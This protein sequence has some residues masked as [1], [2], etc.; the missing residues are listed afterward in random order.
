MYKR[1]NQ[2]G[3]ADLIVLL[4]MSFHWYRGI[5]LQGVSSFESSGLV[6]HLDGFGDS[7]QIADLNADGYPDVVF[8]TT[9]DSSIVWF[10]N[11]RGS[12]FKPAAMVAAAGT[13]PQ[14]FGTQLADIDNDGDLDL[15]VSTRVG[16]GANVVIWFTNDGNGVFERQINIPIPDGANAGRCLSADVDG[17]GYPDLLVSAMD[18][19]YCFPSSARPTRTLTVTTTGSNVQCA[20]NMLL[21]CRTISHAIA[22]GRLTRGGRL[23]ILVDPGTYEEGDRLNLEGRSLIIRSTDATGVVEIRCNAN[24]PHL[25]SGCLRVTARARGLYGSFLIQGGVTFAEASSTLIESAS[26]PGGSYGMFQ[27]SSFT[28]TKSIVSFFHISVRVASRVTATQSTIRFGIWESDF[29]DPIVTGF[30]KLDS[31]TLIGEG[32][33]IDGASAYQPP[34]TSGGAILARASVIDVFKVSFASN[35]ANDR[36]GAVFL[37]GS[38]LLVR[39]LHLESNQAAFQGG[40]IYAEKGSEISVTSRL[41]AVGNSA[42]AGGGAIFGLATMIHIAPYDHCEIRSNSAAFGGALAVAVTAQLT[43]SACNLHDN[44]ATRGG[45]GALYAS[46]AQVELTSCTLSNNEALDVGNGNGGACFLEDTPTIVTQATMQNNTAGNIGGAVYCAGSAFTQSVLSFSQSV[47]HRNKA[48]VSG[49]ALGVDHCG[50]GSDSVNWTSNEAQGP[51]CTPS[52][53]G[54]A[55]YVHRNRWFWS[56]RSGAVTENKAQCNGGAFLLSPLATDARLF[57]DSPSVFDNEAITGGGGAMYW[58]PAESQ[59]TSTPGQFIGLSL[60]DFRTG[61]PGNNRAGYGDAFATSKIAL[62]LCQPSTALENEQQSGRLFTGQ[63]SL[64]FYDAYDVVAVS[65]S[66]TMRVLYS[67]DNALVGPLTSPENGVIN[68][69]G[70]IGLIGAPGASHSLTFRVELPVTADPAAQAR[71]QFTAV[72]ALAACKAGTKIEDSVCRDCPIGSFSEVDSATACDLCEE[73]KFTNTTKQSVCME[74]SEGRFND[75]KGASLCR[76]CAVGSYAQYPASKS[77]D[78]CREGEYMNL[79]GQWYCEGCPMGTYNDLQGASFCRDCPLGTSTALANF[80]TGCLECDPGR[81]NNLTGQSD[82]QYCM[83]GTLADVAGSITCLPCAPGTFVDD[84]RGCRECEAGTYS[85][86]SGSTICE[87]CDEGELDSTRLELRACGVV[88]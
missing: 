82:C 9:A 1:Q 50:F 6:V 27:A 41:E 22:V 29:L 86:R 58:S 83:E 75:V 55:F 19:I 39:E 24:S 87:P 69:T 68:Y 34:D 85:N 71:M 40:A 33:R 20:T 74:C 61:S 28:F 72:V 79:T 5:V 53:G 35:G 59:L 38:K 65:E 80:A 73:G 78:P 47:I 66:D 81:Y 63:L 8:P 42:F 14:P 84:D 51:I 4:T 64:C 2:D 10:Q 36:G 30:M 60:N 11:D 16:F 37:T 46:R 26:I 3:V 70:R 88:L 18:A 15:F 49:G 62:K 17:D 76:D 45:G 23:S 32:L 25:S 48:G 7:L 44:R 21:P 52:T 12:A 43:M 54:G 31:S 67:Q 77:C 57:M 56:M 13:T